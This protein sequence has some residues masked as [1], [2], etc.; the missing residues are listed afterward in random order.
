MKD[1]N[2]AIDKGYGKN[3]VFL[4]EES[5]SID[6]LVQYVKSFAKGYSKEAISPVI[7]ASVVE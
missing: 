3:Q 4:K 5:N 7:L 6:S 1:W 2:H